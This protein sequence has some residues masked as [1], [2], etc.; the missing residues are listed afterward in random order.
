[1]DEKIKHSY[2]GYEYKQLHASGERMSMLLDGYTS[3]GWMPD[4]KAEF[5][6]GTRKIVL[7]RDRKIINKTELTRLQRNFEACVNEIDM[8]EKSRT[9]NATIASIIVGCVGIAFMAGS[10]FAITAVQPIIWLSVVLA[11]PAFALCAIAPAVYKR[12]LAKRSKIVDELI[13]KKYDEIYD[14]CQKGNSLLM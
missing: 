12:M 2:I 10:V 11:V 13:E 9:T 3:F 6:S 8:L 7:R 1:M 4:D 14:I 5:N